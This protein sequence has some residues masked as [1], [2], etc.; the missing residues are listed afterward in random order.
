MNGWLSRC[1]IQP[2]A[3]QI[4]GVEKIVANPF[5][6]LAD[7]MGAGKTMQA[8]VAAQLLYAANQID[9]VIV[10]APASVRAVWFD[11]ELG[12][13]AKYLWKDIAHIVTE[14]HARERTWIFGESPHKPLVWLVTNYDF[15]RS[16]NRL[17]QLKGY[18]SKRALLICD[19]SS[20][21]KN[22]KAQ[23]TK[24]VKE[25]RKLCGRVLMLNG[26]PIANSPRDMYSQGNILHPKILETPYVYQFDA[27]YAVKGGWENRQDIGWKN[28]DDMQNRFKPYTLRRLK[29]DCLDLP[30]KLPPVIL[31]ATLT[32]E[33]WRIYKAMRDELIAWLDNPRAH[34]VAAQAIVKALRLAQITAGFLGGVQQSFEPEGRPEWVPFSETEC[35]DFLDLPDS[36][37]ETVAQVIG[38]EK[39]DVYLEWVE[40]QLVADPSFKLLTW[41]KF[42]PEL[43]RVHA[44]LSTKFPL[45]TAR[46]LH[47]DQRRTDREE[48]VRLLDIRT[49][50]EGAAVLIGTPGTGAMG[51]SFVACHTVMYLSDCTLFEYLQ[52]QD[53]VHRPGQTHAVS[54]FHILAA[55]PKGQRTI[56]HTMFKAR[57]AKQDLATWT[58]AA[59]RDALLA[60]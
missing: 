28:L 11:E 33:T 25:L 59:W 54:Y 17:Q 19:E 29:T 58:T 60:E 45:V 1:R 13:L 38:R 30:E 56:D 48:A 47:G 34:S 15:I 26:T 49:A 4:V 55:G 21:V 6:L 39:L 37:Q 20:K 51:H 14:F 32:E 2:Y 16:K 18:C 35:T 44:E 10:V 24:A 7:E 9:R 46:T 43:F 27:R 50:P 53:R 40:Q 42:R 52:S 57:Q 41:C 22:H 36:P 31:T 23:Q 5:F 12:E 3:H 8:I